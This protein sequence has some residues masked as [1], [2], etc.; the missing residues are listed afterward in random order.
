[1]QE[2]QFLYYFY[3]ARQAIEQQNYP[4]A[5]QLLDFCHDINP[6]DG[7]VNDH[8]GVIFASLG[9]K[10]KA[11]A[12]F[13]KAFEQAP[14]ECGT[15]YQNYLLDKK[16]WKKALKVQDKLDAVNGYDATSALNRYQIYL[17][18]GKGNKAVA[19]I[20]RYL[21]T[22]PQSL[23]FLLFRAD[24][25]AQMEDYEKVFDMC[26]RIAD[27]YPLSGQEYELIRKSACC[28]YYVSAIYTIKA[29][30]LMSVDE[31][32]E[33]IQRYEIALYLMPQNMRALNNYAYGLATHNG[34]L[35]KAEKMSA[36]TIKAEPD[37]P[38]YLDTYAWILHLKGQDTLAL[39]YLRKALENTKEPEVR[40]VIE[41]H[42][43]EINR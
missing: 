9:Q 29:D 12:Y 4:R 40:K 41:E 22:D 25:Y 10:E 11:G 6:D 17:G 37:N 7:I 38:V 3:A 23:N 31:I 26:M 27:L 18:M 36:A 35:T 39:F 20:D 42:M 13:A 8:L 14:S 15:H 30:S 34:D 28:T 43:T 21:S 33:A 16:E 2:Q 24:I 32:P 1:M 19:E 5:L